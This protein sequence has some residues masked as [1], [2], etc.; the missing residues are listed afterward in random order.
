MWKEHLGLC[1]LA[2]QSDCCA[3]DHLRT[4]VI[5]KKVV[6]HIL[7]R[8]NYQ[9][10]KLMEIFWKKNVHKWV[11]LKSFDTSVLNKIS[12]NRIKKNKWNSFPE[13]NNVSNISV[14]KRFGTLTG[15]QLFFNSIQQS[16]QEM[17]SS[18]AGITFTT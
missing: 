10:Q 16:L 15:R 1:L 5:G 12:D 4:I 11:L 13:I 2:T 18:P 17:L 7:L 9:Y 14:L 8:W 3:L 6:F